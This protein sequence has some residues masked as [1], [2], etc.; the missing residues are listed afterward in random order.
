MTVTIRK[1]ER[2]GNGW[3]RFTGVVNGVTTV[4]GK[5]IGVRLPASYVESVSDAEADTEVR[6][7]LCAEYDRLSRG[8]G[9]VYAR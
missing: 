4:Q 2:L 5:E 3:V 6:E 9:G 7:A 1:R 8:S